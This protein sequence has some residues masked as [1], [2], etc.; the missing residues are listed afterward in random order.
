MRRTR[1]SARSSL[2]RCLL[3]AAAAIVLLP[4]CASDSR[5]CCC[6][7]P[8]TCT[9]PQAPA[10]DSLQAAAQTAQT[11]RPTAK[12]TSAAPQIQPASFQ[13]PA[14]T[15][16]DQPGLQPARPEVLPPAAGVVAEELTF[17]QAV[18]LCLLNDPRLRAG[19][20][21]IVQA[22]AGAV[23]ASLKPNPL[24]FTD[25]Q[26]LQL[27]KDFTPTRQGGPPQQDVQVGYPIDWFLFGKRAAAMASASQAI[28][29]TQAEY[30]NLIRERVTNAATAFYD[31]VEAD[32]LLILA[33]Q[34][35][36][37]LEQIALTTQNAVTA[38][39]RPQVELN[40]IRLAL[41]ASQRALRDAQT[42]SATAKSSLNALVG[43][44]L[45]NRPYIAQ[46]DFEQPIMLDLPSTAIAF[47]QAVQNRPDLLALRW[48]I[49]QARA[50]VLVEDRNAYPGVTMTLGYTRQYQLHTIGYPDADSWSAALA[51]PL[52]LWDRNQG[53]RLS[54]Q[55]AVTHSQFELAAGE[56]ELWAEVESS[57]AELAAA[58]DNAT[59]V[60]EQE[61]RLAEQVLDSIN[62]SYALGGRT[63]LDELDA[64]RNFRETYRAYTTTRA[65][66]WRARIRYAST[67]G[68]QTLP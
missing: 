24:L 46:A 67:I 25:G 66:Y 36:E 33:G 23:T 51:L 6:T 58:R 10:N 26:L 32:R 60:S 31:V 38:G 55:S 48:K 68:Q 11:P 3:S 44:A 45:T 61:L 37:S 18:E 62:Q 28:R 64:Q 17:D 54:A 22:N 12:A 27:A 47:G 43:G 42:A 63:L 35:V 15:P 14:S 34:D 41:L 1:N 50:N 20:E 59:A 65:N 53:N 57:L 13:P 56:L 7:A 30:E 19:F 9:C 52:P 8:V 49:E 40:R 16:P 4:G 39:G 29:V 5:Q 2:A 21:A